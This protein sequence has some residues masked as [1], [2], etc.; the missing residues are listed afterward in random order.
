VYLWRKRQRA[1]TDNC[2]FSLV[3]GD[4]Y[5][6]FAGE[7]DGDVDAREALGLVDDDDEDEDEDSESYDGGRSG[8]GGGSELEEDD[9][10][11]RGDEMSLIPKTKFRS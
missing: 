4:L 11:G 3:A 1:R 6:A 8:D 2:E 10:R 7:D 9:G 5:D